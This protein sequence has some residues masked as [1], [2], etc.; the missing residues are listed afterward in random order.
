MF[1]AS[2]T[3][4][5]VTLYGNLDSTAL[6]DYDDRIYELTSRIQKT[7]ILQAIK[8]STVSLSQQNLNLGLYYASIDGRFR[9]IISLLGCFGI[10]LSMVLGL[11]HPYCINRRC[12]DAVGSVYIMDGVRDID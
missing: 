8:N 2:T 7:I 10:G 5:R 3:D 12:G 11:H 1:Q 4:E 9:F 6:I